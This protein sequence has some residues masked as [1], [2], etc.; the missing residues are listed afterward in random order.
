MSA[1]YIKRVRLTFNQK[2]EIVK[3]AKSTSAMTY[4]ELTEW[5][6]A[7]FDLPA[8]LNKSTIGRL[9]RDGD[10]LLAQPPDA[11]DRKNK[12]SRCRLELDQRIVEFILLAE[13]ENISISGAMICQ[14]AKRLA[15]KMG[16]PST[17]L[18]RFTPSWLRRL[19][20]RY[21]FHWRRE[22]GGRARGAVEAQDHHRLAPTRRRL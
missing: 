13:L 10:M 14:Q 21:G 8:K 17:S 12:L 9:L 5:A 16:L 15:V 3:I 7:R 1:Q 18:P 11:A 4:N 22:H 2:K 6:V 19:Q 20:E